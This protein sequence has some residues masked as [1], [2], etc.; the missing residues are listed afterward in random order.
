MN[1]FCLIQNHHLIQ[2]SGGPSCTLRVF[3]VSCIWY[4]LRGVMGTCRGSL[5]KREDLILL[6]EGGCLLPTDYTESPR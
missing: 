5:C 4:E 1:L 3:E 2:G 6:V